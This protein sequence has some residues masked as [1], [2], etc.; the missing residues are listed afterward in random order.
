MNEIIKTLTTIKNRLPEVVLITGLYT[1]FALAISFSGLEN[2]KPDDQNATLLIFFAGIAVTLTMF[3]HFGLLRT[4]CLNPDKP[5][6]PIDLIKTA[7]PFFLRLLAFEL[8]ISSIFAISAIFILAVFTGSSD[9]DT[10]RDSTVMTA[11]AFAIPMIV[12]I[13][14]AIFIRA[15]VLVNDCKLSEAYFAMQSFKLSDRK[16]VIILYCMPIIITLALSFIEAPL[17]KTSFAKHA[18]IAVAACITEF[19][20][21]ITFITAVRFISESKPQ[22]A[23]KEKISE[24]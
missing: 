10:Q 7:S 19:F 1:L 2:P 17:I 15:I 24:D 11:L 23:Q 5:A 22:P 4:I 6:S 9:A 20:F 3:L 12:L 18:L 21:L 8:I 16:S 14:P 13:K